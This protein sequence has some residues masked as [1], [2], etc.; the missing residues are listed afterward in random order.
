LH[1]FRRMHSF[2]LGGTVYPGTDGDVR[3]GGTGAGSNSALLKETKVG[4]V[5]IWASWASLQP[6]SSTQAIGQGTASGGPRPITP[7]DHL[8][9]LDDQITFIRTHPWPEIANLK[10]ILQ[11]KEFP[12]WSNSTTRANAAGTP[13][14]HQGPDKRFLAF[15]DAA[16]VNS[17]WAKFVGWVVDRYT[18]TDANPT[19]YVDGID[20]VNEP[21][22]E[23][24]PQQNGRVLPNGT[25]VGSPSAHCTVAQMFASALAQRE[26]AVANLAGSTQIQ[27]KPLLLG[28]GTSDYF[29]TD[30]EGNHDT[31][32]KTTYATFNNNLIAML[33]ANGFKA[34]VDFI[35]SHHNY[36]DASYD[37]GDRTTDPPTDTA[38]RCSVIN[39][40]QYARRL[41]IGRWTGGPYGD[42]NDPY[43]FV[44]EGGI[45]RSQQWAKV[46]GLPYTDS[47]WNEMHGLL[48]QRML[49]RMQNE[50]DGKGVGMVCQYEFYSEHGYDSGI[51]DFDAPP[52]NPPGTQPTSPQTG[53][54]R[55]PAYDIWSNALSYPAVR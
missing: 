8:T 53:A 46:W 49:D 36:D 13:V 22:L 25:F 30:D 24:W 37:L 34:P 5:K 6:T 31:N 4:W 28:P 29:L 19:R 3:Y 20:I 26:A 11:L 27:L 15:P 54:K 43:I 1:T 38:N 40:A 32:T 12:L 16:D 14:E 51:C 21:N 9:A 2:G 7:P 55:Q 44:T 39:R 35:W 50:V 42:A 17:P 33:Q 47:A 52:Q 41:L 48:M 10:I 45:H 18:R 23:C